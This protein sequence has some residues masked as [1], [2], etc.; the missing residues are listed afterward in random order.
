[1]P[2]TYNTKP[3]KTTTPFNKLY[4]QTSTLYATSTKAKTTFIKRPA[5]KGL[6]ILTNKQQT[7]LKHIINLAL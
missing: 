4:Y 1:M 5:F 6:I 2:R 7:L 3:A